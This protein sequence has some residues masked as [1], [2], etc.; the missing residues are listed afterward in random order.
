MDENPYKVP[1][2]EGA[3]TPAKKSAF[4]DPVAN[5]IV[6]LGVVAIIALA[7]MAGMIRAGRF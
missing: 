1:A 2:E 4:L 6:L 7:L 5:L 3:N